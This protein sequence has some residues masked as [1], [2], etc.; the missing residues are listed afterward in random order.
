MAETLSDEDPES[1]V[2]DMILN[3]DIPYLTID[4]ESGILL[5]FFNVPRE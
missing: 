4:K 5:R 3:I 1:E 2:Y